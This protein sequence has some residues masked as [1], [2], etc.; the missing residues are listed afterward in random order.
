MDCRRYFWWFD[1]VE[2]GSVVFLLE[3]GGGY[4]GLGW[5]VVREGLE[6]VICRM[7]TA[8][9]GLSKGFLLV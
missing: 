4:D 1:R 6:E 8:R 5:R 2:R 7:G 3:I 9:D